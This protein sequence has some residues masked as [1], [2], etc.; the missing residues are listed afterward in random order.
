MPEKDLG[1]NQSNDVLDILRD[2]GALKDGHF[3]LS[4]GHHSGQYV[5]KFDLF[6]RPDATSKV[7]SLIADRFKFEQVDVVVGPTTGGV[8]LAFEVARQLN[9]LAAYAER[10]NGGREFRRGTTF[11]GNARAL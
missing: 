10:A 1:L 3:L 9:V 8:I 11:A 2:A 4:S 5:E 6:R 7:C